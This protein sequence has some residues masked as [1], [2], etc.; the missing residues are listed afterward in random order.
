M[1]FSLPTRRR[2]RRALWRIIAA[3]GFCGLALPACRRDR[4]AAP[5]PL[6][7]LFAPQAAALIVDDISVVAHATDAFCKGLTVRTGAAAYAK[8]RE[9]ARSQLGFDPLAPESLAQAGVRT[10][11][12]LA[13]F[14]EPNMAQ[15]LVAIPVDAPATFDAALKGLLS[16]LQGAGET[17]VQTLHGQQITT[18]GRPFGN[19][20]APSAHWLHHRGYT[21]VVRGDG[22]A[23]LSAFAQRRA[24]AAHANLDADEP[25]RTDRQA[26][27]PGPITVTA[28]TRAEHASPGAQLTARARI[29][30]RGLAADARLRLLD[31][32][33]QV[34]TAFGAGLPVMPLAGLVD[35]DALA[36]G[37][38][39]GAQ[40]R[41]GAQ[42]AA[43]TASLGSLAWGRAAPLQAH[44]QTFLQSALMPHLVG[45]VAISIHPRPTTVAAPAA[46]LPRHFGGIVSQLQVAAVVE[47][48][49]LPGLEN[50]LAAQP[51]QL[52]A[53]GV[54]VQVAHPT[55]GGR[56]VTT[57]SIDSGPIPM[58][59]A[60]WPP[61]LVGAVGDGRLLRTLQV[62]A[63]GPTPLGQ[64]APTGV[65]HLWQEQPGSVFLWRGD[66]V[67]AALRQAVPAGAG[68]EGLLAAAAEVLHTLGN[69]AL[70][71]RTEAQ[72]TFGV[73]LRIELR[74]Q[75]Q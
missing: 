28:H 57:Y 18:V 23:A 22:L 68:L 9:A 3:L 16:R 71:L 15:P 21:F 35:D 32:P 56:Q 74:E 52:A 34:Q 51:K 69:V 1:V 54:H 17:T 61:Y 47:V 64:P 7:A 48:D 75:L 37:L 44:A 73:P 14:V 46:S 53:A 31:F 30:G 43:A 49:E 24:G 27:P 58:G 50:L 2:P 25:H 8:L 38:S 13:L 36:L 6:E 11:G 33:P 10:S 12:S 20:V 70:G 19:T 45:P 42:A 59:W 41:Y 5:Q 39:R 60:L 66:A 72:D 65:A 26:L 4:T 55:I 40:G 63:A 29:D 62:L 67:A